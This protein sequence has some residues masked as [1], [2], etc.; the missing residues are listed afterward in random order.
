MATHENY[1]DSR[2]LTMTQYSN[3]YGLPY[4]TLTKDTFNI[5][6][7]GLDF[8]DTEQP[9]KIGEIYDYDKKTACDIID[10][11]VFVGYICSTCWGH[12]ITDSLARLWW[13]TNEDYSEKYKDALLFYISEKP[14]SDNYLS[15]LQL[16]GVKTENLRIV[17]SVV[18]FS[19]VVIPEPCFNNSLAS[20]RYTLE[21][22]TIINRLI[23]INI[24]TKTYQKVYFAK[25]DSTRQI[26][27][28]KIKNILSE[29]GFVTIYPEKLSVQDQ[30]SILQNADIIVSEECSLSHN[31]VFCKDNARVVILRKANTINVYQAVVNQMRKLNV[32]YID[33]HLSILNDPDHPHR[34]PFFLYAND[35]FC[36]YFQK[37]SSVFPYNEF[38]TYLQNGIVKGQK[39]DARYKEILNKMYTHLIKRGKK[40]SYLLRHD[41]S[42]T[43]D[44]HG[45]R[46][47]SDLVANHGFTMEEL[48]E[49]VANNNKQ[50]YEFSEDMMRIRARQGHSIQ[51]DVELVEAAP[52]DLLYHGTAKAFVKSIMSQGV[53]KGNRLYVHLSTTIDAA[54]K[55]GA[56][57]GEPVVLCIDAKRMHEDGIMFF[58]SRN[59]VWLTEFVDVKYINGTDKP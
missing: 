32:V 50:R 30:I 12:T 57:H 47:V 46:E 55:V 42:Y 8:M 22:I 16:L 53:Q 58:L 28:I 52:P 44:E 43:F 34:G 4:R 40:L 14:L 59:G 31:F 26:T 38:Y 6:G 23:S 51:V 39:W 35:C 10:T 13:I 5:V 20:I 56:R 7:G 24:S 29:E 36:H 15:I 21:Y 19:S 37:E 17:D 41:K 27:S 48:R 18:H 2:V 1:L 33:C 25:E 11:V 9:Y 45:W 54:T 49:I 3:C